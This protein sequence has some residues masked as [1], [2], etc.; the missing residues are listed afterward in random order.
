MYS[1]EEILFYAFTVSNNR[2]G[3][4]FQKDKVLITYDNKYR[5]YV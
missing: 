4:K 2:S 1:D 3:R 5:F